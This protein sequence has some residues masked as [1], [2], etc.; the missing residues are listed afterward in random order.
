MGNQMFQYA[1][2]HIVAKKHRTLFWLGTNDVKFDL[3]WF[4]LGIPYRFLDIPWLFKAYNFLQK[5]V[6]PTN[7]LDFSD[8]TKQFPENTFHDNTC[9]KGYFQYA[10]LMENYRNELSVLFTPKK[11]IAS[12]FKA[13]FHGTISSH[14]ILVISLRLGD[15]HQYQLTEY[16]SASIIVPISWYKSIIAE[17][18]NITLYKTFV[19]SDDIED[20]RK[21]TADFLSDAVYVDE[22]PNIQ[23][24]LLM[25]ADI[26]V[27]SNSTFAWWGGFL[28]LRP[29]SRIIAPKYFLGFNV[30]KEFPAGITTSYF[31][32]K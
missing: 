4:D 11:K 10:Y 13:K 18:P 27:L 8:S 15:Y 32:W 5:F 29:N 19:I 21:Q 6:C 28:N 1:F 9:Y 14:K 2:A 23:F 3:L 31:E 24:Q 7:T 25:H 16:D 12:L 30:Q 17:I 26:A 22:H 20:A